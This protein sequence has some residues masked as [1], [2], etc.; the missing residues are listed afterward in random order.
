MIRCRRAVGRGHHP[1]ATKESICQERASL[2]V[3]LGSPGKREGSG[4]GSRAGGTRAGVPS[5]EL[6]RPGGPGVSLGGIS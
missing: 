2:Q 1:S 6:P 4:P 5:C 3:S